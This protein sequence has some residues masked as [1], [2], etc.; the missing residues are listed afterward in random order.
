M[1]RDQPTVPYPRDLGEHPTVPL[2][3]LAGPVR[4]RRR[5][6][7]VLLAAV[8][9]IAGLLVAAEFITR[10]IV[11]RTV[12]AQVVQAL[13]LPADQPMTV[14]AGGILLPQ[15][16]AG[17]L[18]ELRLSSD[19]VTLGQV[20]AAVDVT[21]QGVPLRGGDLTAAWGSL[22]IGEAEFA[23]LLIGM[24]LPVEEVSLAEPDVQLGGSFRVFGAEIP[25]TLTLTPGAEGGD[26]LLTA[27]S[28]SLGGAEI[29]IATLGSRLGAV[30]AAL[31]GPQRICVADRLPSGLR[32][33]GLRVEGAEIVADIVV[34]PAIA[35][36]PV[37]L[38]PGVCG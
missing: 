14:E 16:I 7:W 17:R 35:T 3:D 29:D 2:P 1:S 34:D 33:E 38:D 10:G 18:D 11:D 13:Q 28:A 20:T 32:L 6:P 36:D 21:A 30:G 24:D 15:V 37:L 4:R 5:W 22:R 27:V 12:R 25:V 19:A 8:V 26:I 23:R 31:A 9:V